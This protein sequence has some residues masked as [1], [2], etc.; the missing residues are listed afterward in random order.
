MTYDVVAVNI[1]TSTVRVI[2][3]NKS[4][5][6]A[7]A[8]VSMAVMQ[9]GVEEEFFAEVKTGAYKTGDAWKG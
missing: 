3:T 2:G 9:R 7:E 5:E 6:N 8:I 1:S 4:K